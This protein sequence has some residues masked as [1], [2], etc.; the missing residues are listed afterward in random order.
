MLWEQFGQ[1]QCPVSL[2]LDDVLQIT[3]IVI[4]GRAQ[5]PRLDA[6]QFPQTARVAVLVD[7]GFASKGRATG[8]C[9]NCTG[10]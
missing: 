3:L 5:I 1:S 4:F 9:S 7:D 6:L 2:C 10:H 8:I